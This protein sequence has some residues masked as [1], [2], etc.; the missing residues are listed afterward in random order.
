ML[1]NLLSTT[2]ARLIIAVINLSIVWISA[3]FLGAE[4]LG[5]ISLIIL[6]ISIIQL[7]TAVLA[8]SSLVYQVSRHP[9]AELLIIAWIW[10]LII[11]PV[12]W[13]LLSAFSLI[14]A[15]FEVDVLILSVIGGIVTVN[16]NVFLGQGK[17]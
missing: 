2:S 16:Q 8:G 11:S 15:G 17:K 7:F 9:L 3:R 1:R 13:L 4:I 5:T 10:I 14:P 6:G 12:V